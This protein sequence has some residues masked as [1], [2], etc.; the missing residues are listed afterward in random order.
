V[1]P[2][3]VFDGNP[4]LFPLLLEKNPENPYFLLEKCGD[5]CAGIHKII[6]RKNMKI[7]R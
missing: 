5:I 7:R 1:P 2:F 6:I 3:G 4:I